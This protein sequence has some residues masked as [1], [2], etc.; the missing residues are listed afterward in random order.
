MKCRFGVVLSLILLGASL[1]RAVATPVK[2]EVRNIAGGWQLLRGGKPY[3]IHGAA[4]DEALALL[5]RLGGNSIRTWSTGGSDTT[6]LLADANQLE[7]TV[8]A[9]LELQPARHGFNYHNPAQV[10][11]QYQQTIGVVE[12]YKD[13][14]AI[15]I[16]GIGNEMEGDGTDPAVWKAVNDIARAI[17]RIDPDH[18]TMTVI[19]GTGERSIKLVNFMKYCPDVDILGI[20]SYGGMATLIEEVRAQKLNRPYIVT[21]FGPIGWWEVPKTSWGAPLE[22]TSTEKAV[23]YRH[24]Y[25]HSVKGAGDLCLGSYAFL[26]GWKQER[27]Y[28]WFGMLLPDSTQPN[29][30]DKTAA[31]D[32][33]SYEWTGWWPTNRAPKI[34]PIQ[35]KAGKKAVSPGTVMRAYV[36]ASDPDGD[37]LIYQWTV[38]E[39]THD[40]KEGGDPEQAPPVVRGAIVRQSGSRVTF[41]A[42]EKAG[43]YRVFVEV[44][45]GKGNVATANVPFLVK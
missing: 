35:T 3:Y 28:S 42:P 34:S 6:T 5:R 11:E 2:V 18:P 36:K 20:N 23:T 30:V 13:N 24:S 25:E 15:L 21:E 22:Q 27:T 44:R 4:G 38:R 32:V 33:I 19:A 40:A 10:K 43:P 7:L 45:D 31:A 17:H 14:A 37:K 26:W 8:A 16:W 29:G 1:Q 41:R 9:G 39:E 12:K